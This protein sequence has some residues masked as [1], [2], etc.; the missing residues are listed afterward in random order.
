MV[1][2]RRCINTQKLYIL[3]L[4]KRHDLNTMKED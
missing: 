2:F 1:D 3:I 4:N